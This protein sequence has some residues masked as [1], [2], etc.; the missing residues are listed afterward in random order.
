M[1]K[2]KPVMKEHQE[3]Q[4][5][6]VE[7]HTGPKPMSLLE[8]ADAQVGHDFLSGLLNVA[9]DVGKVVEQNQHGTATNPPG[10]T[11]SNTTAQGGIQQLSQE[12]LAKLTL[13]LGSLIGAIQGKATDPSQKKT[14]AEEVKKAADEP[15]VDDV[16]EEIGKVV[17]PGYTG[18]KDA[19]AVSKPKAT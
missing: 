19:S 5:T 7:A 9:K 8:K 1:F 15:V 2:T 10:R 11:H 6:K 12:D 18:Y 13:G 17:L 3:E 4:M 14:P 16:E